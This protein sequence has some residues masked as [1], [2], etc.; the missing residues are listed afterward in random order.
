MVE[1]RSPVAMA[2]LEV[3]D[4]REGADASLKDSVLSRLHGRIALPHEGGIATYATQEDVP[5][6]KDFPVYYSLRSLEKVAVLRHRNN[7]KVQLRLL[8]DN[9]KGQARI[10]LKVFVN[11]GNRWRPGLNPGEFRFPSDDELSKGITEMSK[12]ELTERICRV[13]VLCLYK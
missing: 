7:R 4:E 2:F 12:E 3:A 9:E 13:L 6:D 10:A 1:D 5:A 8:P 11:E